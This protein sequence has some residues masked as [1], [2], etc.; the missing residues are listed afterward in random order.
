MKRMAWLSI[1]AGLAGCEVD[2]NNT[3]E[4][5]DEDTA[6]HISQIL[7]V[8]SSSRIDFKNVQTFLHEEVFT[9]GQANGKSFLVRG[10]KTFIAGDEKTQ[11]TI[12]TCCIS[13]DSYY[14]FRDKPK[15]T[16]EFTK[17][18]AE[19]SC[20]AF[21]EA[22]SRFNL[23]KV[24]DDVEP[25]TSGPALDTAATILNLNGKPCAEVR[26]LVERDSSSGILYEVDC[27][28]YRNGSGRK[29]ILHKSEDR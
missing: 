9:C 5:H 25:I 14:T 23:S 11:Y 15:I 18:S 19:K 20:G 8:L 13:L 16:T 24:K 2:Y 17:E 6:G 21:T 28:E 12:S 3:T 29:T 26:S 1:F 4:L 10:G 27:I 22:T 7:S